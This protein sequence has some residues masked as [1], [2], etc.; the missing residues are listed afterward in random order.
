MEISDIKITHIIDYLGAKGF[1][2]VKINSNTALYFSPFREE[3]TLSFNVSMKK[4]V[5]F[6]FGPGEGG[7]LVKLVMMLENYSLNEA[8]T[9]LN[10]NL[11]SRLVRDLPPFDENEH[12]RI[13]H[14]R[15]LQRR[16]L[17]KYLDSRRIS[18]IFS[19]K[20]LKEAN[21]T[22]HH[23]KYFALAFK[24]DRGG[25]ELRNEFF[26][27]G[28]SPKY[29][30]TIPGPDPTRLSVF[31]GF[32]D[33]LSACTYYDQL[34]GCK[35]IILNSLSFLPRIESELAIAKTVN[36]YLDNDTAGRKATQKTLDSHP[37]AKDWA[38]IVYPDFKDFNDFLMA[39]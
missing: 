18:L 25:Y 32:M 12:I 27:G 6:D 29:F 28:S 37:H 24:N 3:K 30:T 1:Q 34:P 19:R 9:N 11:H 20:Y 7:N 8:L 26:K 2:P 36:L 15:L 35:T 10:G 23:K 17:T 14:T 39:L 4:N 21:Y 31:E 16:S 33:F 5:W 22:V 13:T 38:Q